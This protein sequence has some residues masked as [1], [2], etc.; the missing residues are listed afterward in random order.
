[1]WDGRYVAGVSE[2]SPLVRRTE[3]VTHREGG[4]P[5]T[6]RK[7]PGRTEYDAITL[8]RGVTQDTE[9]EAW[10]NKVWNYGSSLGQEVSLADFRKER[11]PGSDERGWAGCP[12]IPDLPL[13]GFV[14]SG[15]PG[16]GRELG[17][18]C[19]SVYHAGERG[20]GPRHERGGAQGTDSQ[21]FVADSHSLR[22][23]LAGMR[24]GGSFM[25]AGSSASQRIWDRLALCQAT[26]HT[27]R[28]GG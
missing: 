7:S 23:T 1:M 20:V 3:V 26:M 24:I 16:P 27:A 8:S 21:R 25:W 10:A 28:P 14:L 2:V 4:D 5:S 11:H 13:L 22:M 9:F 15:A 17:S 18:R 6:S 19:D 12:S